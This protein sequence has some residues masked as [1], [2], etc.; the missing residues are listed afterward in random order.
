MR[1]LREKMNN[2]YSKTLTNPYRILEKCIYENLQPL[3]QETF[4]HSLYIK[5][6]NILYFNSYFPG[7]NFDICFNTS[8]TLLLL[9][10]DDTR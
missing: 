5:V 9:F 7:N 3:Y 8:V 1:L 6:L 10:E 4:Q 2:N